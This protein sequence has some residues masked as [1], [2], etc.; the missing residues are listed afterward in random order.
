MQQSGTALRFACA[1]ARDIL[2]SAAAAKLGVPATELKVSDGSVSA[3]G[4]GLSYQWSRDG[5]PVPGATGPALRLPAA[6]AADAGAYA[7]AVRNARG[8]ATSAPAALRLAAPDDRPRLCNL[9]ARALAGAGDRTL[10]VG[11]V[12]SGP[13]P[14]Q[15]LPVLLRGIGPGIAS[16]DV[17]GATA[18]VVTRHGPAT[19]PCSTGAVLGVA[20][21]L[22]P[23]GVNLNF[24]P[25][26]ESSYINPPLMMVKIAMPLL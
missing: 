2:L 3:S 21:F 17:A 20:H 11:L 23:A 22:P 26:A 24:C 9:S 13:D 19:D 12:V 18:D 25:A 8:E 4:G 16:M 14:A 1:E 6:S 15:G 5:V 7:V 10:M